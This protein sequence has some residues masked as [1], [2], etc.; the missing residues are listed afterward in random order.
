[1]QH[2]FKKLR[3]LHAHLESVEKSA[4]ISFEKVINEKVTEKW[5]F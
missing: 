3:L 1:M 5:S 4:K 2:G